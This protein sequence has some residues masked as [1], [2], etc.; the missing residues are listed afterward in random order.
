MNFNF[1]NVSDHVVKIWNN[2]TEENRVN[3]YT[4][5]GKEPNKSQLFES[6]LEEYNSLKNKN[7]RQDEKIKELTKKIEINK[8]DDD[9]KNA[10]K[11][12]TGMSI[13]KLPKES[14]T[15]YLGEGQMMCITFAGPTIVEKGHKDP[16]TGLELISNIKFFLTYG[17]PEK[18]Y[19]LPIYKD[20]YIF[21]SISFQLE[22]IK[23][24]MPEI[25]ELYRTGRADLTGAT[26]FIRCIRKN[27]RCATYVEPKYVPNIKT[28]DKIIEDK[29]SNFKN[30]QQLLDDGLKKLPGAAYK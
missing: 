27:V 29:I 7:M 12:L 15:I 25:V 24:T 8:I 10:L 23:M 30:R 18:F 6:F 14:Q 13:I 26:F 28:K 20:D 1:P 11:I 16:I 17:D 19:Y 9:T 2:F 21:Y 22:F 5:L 3:I 4:K